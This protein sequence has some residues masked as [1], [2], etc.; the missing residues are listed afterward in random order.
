MDQGKLEETEASFMSYAEITRRLIVQ[1]PKNAMWVLEMA[2][3]LTNLG[4]LHKSRDMN[5]PERTLQFMQSALEYNQI[6]LVLDPSNENY[7]AQLGQSHANLSDAQLKICDLEGAL[8][9]RQ[10]WLLQDEALLQIEPKNPTR[11][12]HVAL[13]LTGHASVMTFLGRNSEALDSL[14]KALHLFEDLLVQEVDVDNTTRLILI[15]ERQLVLLMALNGNVDGAWE[16]STAVAEKWRQMKDVDEEDMRTRLFYAAFLMTHAQLAKTVGELE[17]AEGLLENIDE[18]LTSSLSHRSFSRET[19]NLLVHSAFL[20]WEMKKELPA[21][22]IRSLL[23]EY[24]AGSGRV[25]ACVDASSAV[26]KAVMSGQLETARE[27]SLY[28]LHNGY[29]EAEFLR[30]CNAHSLCEVH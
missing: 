17:I 8:Q 15:R 18:I 13:A 21:A 16:L 27:F 7:R 9:S 20:R 23:P 24:E 26:L 11:I 6:A 25:R 30:I 4:S 2:Y 29:R 19:G 3:A 1:Q 22:K 5:N 10:E 14:N 28:L 12:R